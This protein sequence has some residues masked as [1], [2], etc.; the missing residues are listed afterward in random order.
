M[1]GWDSLVLLQHLLDDGL[2]KSAIAQRLGV[3][4]RVIYHWLATGQLTRD[5]DA[6]VPRQYAQRPSRLDPFTEIVATSTKLA[7]GIRVVIPAMQRP[8]GTLTT[9]RIMLA[10]VRA[11][12]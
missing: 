9:S 8:D 2:S 12:K 4:R 6:P 5:V 10:N 11:S 1:H 3:I 7:P